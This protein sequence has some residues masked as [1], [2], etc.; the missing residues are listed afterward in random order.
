MSFFAILIALLLEQARPLAY[1]NVVHSGLRAW[2]RLVRRNFDGGEH[3]HGWLAWVLA[4][5]VPALIAWVVYWVLWQFSSVL[6]FVWLTGVLYVTVGFRQFS[7]HF[8][9]IRQALETGDDLAAREKLA[10]WLRV[11]AASLPRAELLRQ[12]IEHAVLAAHRHVFGVLI[13]FGVFWALGFGPAGAVFYRM[14]EYISRNWRER[15]DGTPS[16]ALRE[17]ARRA[18]EAVDYVPARITAL[19]FAIVGNFEESVACWRGEAEQFAPGS[20]GVLLAATSG[21]LGV[22]LNRMA[23]NGALTGEDT[24]EAPTRA[25]PQISHLASAVGLVWRSVVLWMLLL[26]LLTVARWQI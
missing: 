25:E 7:H 5:G 10:R 22:R 15:A 23:S 26:A 6:G 16:P 21:A 20:D 2:A 17:A 12:V 18:W 13:C 4:V 11:D 3:T 19:G 1:N 9:D 24:V 8:T 14:A